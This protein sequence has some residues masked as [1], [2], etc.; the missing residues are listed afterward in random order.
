[1]PAPCQEAYLVMHV[2]LQKPD[3]RH[4]LGQWLQPNKLLLCHVHS[5]HFFYLFVCPWWALGGFL[6]VT[7]MI[8]NIFEE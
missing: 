2:V 3:P 7:M 4:K 1:M 5:S 6:G 8:K